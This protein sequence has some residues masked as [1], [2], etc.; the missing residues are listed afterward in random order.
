MK[1]ALVFSVGVLLYLKS[2]AGFITLEGSYQGKNLFVQNPFAG[3]GVGFCT[4]E[5]LVNDITS[6]DEI[7]SSAF[8]IDFTNFKL[9][10]GDKIS[11]KIKHK[12][13]CKPKVLNPEVLKPSSTYELISF[14]VDEGGLRW[15]TKGESGSLPFVVE[16]YRWNKW[17]KVGEISGKGTPDANDYTF[18]VK[19]H[20]GINKYRIQQTDYTNNPKYSSPVQFRAT[21]PEVTFYPAKVSKDINFSTETMFEIFDKYGNLVKKGVGAQ[22]DCSKLEQGIYQINYDNKMGNFIKK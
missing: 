1:K 22:V 19:H 15:T 6:T 5:V 3:S 21:M 13:D 8:E 7:Q 18:K 16:Q 2:S 11:I 14:K 20:S 10:L 9:K 12:D 17:I 4:T